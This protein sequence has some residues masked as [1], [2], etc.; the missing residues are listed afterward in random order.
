MTIIR[1]EFMK[2]IKWIAFWGI[3]QNGKDCLCTWKFLSFVLKNATIEFQRVMD[4]VLVG[5]AF[6][7][8]YIE[9]DICIQ[10]YILLS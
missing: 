5:L 7:K 10:F 3:H 9:D 8:C 2:V 4:Q 1:F 6:T